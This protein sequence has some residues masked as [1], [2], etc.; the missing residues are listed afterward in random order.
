MTIIVIL[1]G[2][3]VQPSLPALW[4]QRQVGLCEFEASFIYKSNIEKP[5]FK[6]KVKQQST[7]HPQKEVNLYHAL[8][9]A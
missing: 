7:I 6:N 9:S 2:L 5:C 1:R 3:R 4:T 8:E